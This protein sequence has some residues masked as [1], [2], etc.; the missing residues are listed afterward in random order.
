MVSHVAHAEGRARAEQSREQLLNQR[1]TVVRNTQPLQICFDRCGSRTGQTQ[2]DT[3]GSVGL[4]ATQTSYEEHSE[5]RRRAASR[6]FIRF[7]VCLRRLSLYLPA[8]CRLKQQSE[9]L[10]QPDL[11]EISGFMDGSAPVKRIVSMRKLRANEL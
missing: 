9:L 3:L 2:G 8:G 1:R 7:A 10:D 11:Q 6:A 5:H 4:E